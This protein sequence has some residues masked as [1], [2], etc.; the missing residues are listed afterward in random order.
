MRLGNQIYKIATL[1]L[2]V[3]LLVPLSVSGAAEGFCQIGNVRVPCPTENLA[4]PAGAQSFGSLITI[5]L[6]ILLFVVGSISVVFFIIGGF[7]YVTAHGNEEQAE[8]A[9]KTMTHAIIGLIV[10]IMSFAI[11]AIITQVLIS[12]KGGT[13]I[14]T[15]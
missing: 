10:V 1:G 9:K 6:S 4:G 7:R 15:P 13:G 14:L 2:M 8:G 12:G 5:I 3:L 11:I